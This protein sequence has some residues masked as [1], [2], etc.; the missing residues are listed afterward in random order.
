MPHR[1]WA[2]SAAPLVEE[3]IEGFLLKLVCPFAPTFSP[4]QRLAI[5]A[6]KIPYVGEHYSADLHKPEHVFL[7]CA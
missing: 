3:D 2:L 5:A 1:A 4:L 6:K 7:A